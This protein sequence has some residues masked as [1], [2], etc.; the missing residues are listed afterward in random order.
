MRTFVLML[1]L[2]LAAPV[3]ASVGSTL[4]PQ[5]SG[6]QYVQNTP[7]SG[8]WTEPGGGG[9]T[10]HL[11]E[12]PVGALGAYVYFYN[13]DESG[14][15]ESQ[16]IVQDPGSYPWTDL[17][18]QDVFYVQVVFVGR[19]GKGFEMMAHN[20]TVCIATDSAYTDF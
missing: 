2:V 11:E 5:L 18:L 4:P 19:F 3:V 20:R 17:S 15:V 7:G 16:F 1:C 8:L 14:T 12:W 6:C 13:Y 9:L 10:V